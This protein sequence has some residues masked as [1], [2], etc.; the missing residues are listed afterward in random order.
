MQLDFFPLL[1]VEK[2]PE[3]RFEDIDPVADT[4]ERIKRLR[5]SEECGK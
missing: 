2:K 4:R 3:L 5:E 1:T